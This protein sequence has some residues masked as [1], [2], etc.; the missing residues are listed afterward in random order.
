MQSR[1]LPTV[2]MTVVMRRAYHFERYPPRLATFARAFQI[3]LPIAAAGAAR[4][5]TLIRDGLLKRM[6]FYE[7]RKTRFCYEPTC[8]QNRSRWLLARSK[9]ALPFTL[10][11]WPQIRFFRTPNAYSMRKIFGAASHCS[12]IAVE[13]GYASRQ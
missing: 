12:T 9:S 6:W 7:C 1:F 10:N 4:R 11:V 3:F 2:E 13:C 8:I 5:L